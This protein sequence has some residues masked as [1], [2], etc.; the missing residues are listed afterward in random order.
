V[1][2]DLSFDQAPP[3]SV[4]F[5][6]FLTAPW[7]GVAAGILLLLQGGDLF[8]S[9]WTPG[10]LALTHLLTLGFMLQAMTGAVLQFVPV[11]TGGNVWRATL[12]ASIVHPAFAAGAVLL[13][14]GFLFPWPHCL[15]AAAVLIASAGTLLVGTAGRALC[16]TP[17]VG[18]TVAAMRGAVIALAI[19]LG[20]GAFLA[21]GLAAEIIVVTQVHVAWGLGGWA[22]LLLAGVAVTVVPMFQLTPAYPLRA[23]KMFPWVVIGGLLLWSGRLFGVVQDL[24]RL[25]LFALLALAAAFVVTTL[26]LQARRR[27]KV[28]DTNALMMRSAMGTGLIS[29]V[30]CGWLTAGLPGSDD[31]RLQVAAGVLLVAPFVF[32]INGMLYKIVPF[33]NWLHLQRH[34][35]PRALPPNMNKMIPARSMERQARTQLFAFALLLAASQWPALARPAGAA[36]VVSFGWL[37]WNLIGAATTYRRF[38]RQIP[39]A[40]RHGNS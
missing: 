8:V 21:S 7:F 32:A 2:A 14:A 30:L 20:L 17:A 25:G 12:V 19:T 5:R 31:D 40:A 11:A 28:A 18:A 34:G 38:K 36:L 4:P 33:L 10:A 6:F 13:C 16:T 29:I 35:G 3:I 23:A 22:L 24:T 26:R 27:R 39:A 15:E 37:G 1:S 9:R